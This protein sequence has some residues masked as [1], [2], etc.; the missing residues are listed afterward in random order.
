MDDQPPRR[1]SNKFLID[2]PLKDVT[3]GRRFGGLP[4]GKGRWQRIS[5]LGVLWTDDKEALQLGILK[6]QDNELAN[7]LRRRMVMMAVDGMAATAAFDVI[8]SENGKYMIV[9]GD[10]ADRGED[11]F[12]N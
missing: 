10:L 12:W 9:H 7:A 8:A 11:N 5:H 2:Y 1:R 4:E 3:V 6:S